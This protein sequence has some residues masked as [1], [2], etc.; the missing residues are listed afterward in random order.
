MLFHQIGQRRL[1][2]KSVISSSNEKRAQVSYAMDCG[3]CAK[4]V[5]RESATRYGADKLSDIRETDIDKDRVDTNDC[6][7]SSIKY[8]TMIRYP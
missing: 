8:D 5:V 2:T 3:A 1:G 7:A 4:E 6:I